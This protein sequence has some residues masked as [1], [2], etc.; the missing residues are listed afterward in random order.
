MSSNKKLKG[1]NCLD[2][3]VSHLFA[4][5]LSGVIERIGFFFS[6]KVNMSHGETWR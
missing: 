1:G 2:Q 5:L 6:L 3:R 4:G